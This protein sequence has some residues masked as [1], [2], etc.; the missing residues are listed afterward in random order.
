MK[1]SEEIVRSPSVGLMVRSTPCVTV[2]FDLHILMPCS[3]RVG[4][5][6]HRLATFIFLSISKL[7]SCTYLTI[8]VLSRCKRI[9]VQLQ[10]G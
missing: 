6:P 8:S 4:L 3:D 5:S 7:V 2:T 10:V 1:E 9:G